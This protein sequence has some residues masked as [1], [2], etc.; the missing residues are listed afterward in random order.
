MANLNIFHKMF[1][2]KLFLSKNYII[3]FFQFSWGFFSSIY[4][5]PSIYLSIYTLFADCF[6]HKEKPIKKKQWKI[7]LH[8][9]IM[10]KRPGEVATLPRNQQHD[11]TI[12]TQNDALDELIKS[13]TSR[14]C[15]TMTEFFIFCP[16]R[17]VFNIKVDCT[18]YYNYCCR[19]KRGRT[20]YVI[21]GGG[22]TTILRGLMLTQ[23]CSNG[24]R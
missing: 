16:K 18:V 15:A 8:Q 23:Q 3:S 12:I 20:Q 22:G 11:A 2:L 17:N 7:I 9:T 14:L 24:G 19:H 6:Q 13:P 5:Y 4:I 10:A 1:L 21:T